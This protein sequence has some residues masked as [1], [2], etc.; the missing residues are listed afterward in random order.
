MRSFTS[1]SVLTRF[2]FCSLLLSSCLSSKKIDNFVAAQYNYQL[3]KIKNR[4]IPVLPTTSA[5]GTTISTTEPHT[6]VLPLV[7]YWVVDYRHTT[8][9]NS[10]IAVANFANAVN[11]TASRSLNQ[12]LNG[13]KLELTVE[14][15]PSTFAFVDKTHFIWL[16]IYVVHWD[17]IYIE[18]EA[19]DLIVSY[20]LL[21]NETVVKTGRI[22]VKNPEHNKGLRFFQSWKS[23][24]NEYIATYNSDIT[25]MAKQFVTSLS[26]EL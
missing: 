9:L 21:R 17:K 7:L 1:L 15:A 4:D 16:I 5:L 24:I 13:Q 2:L 20:K 6:K 25:V 3:P 23:A 22:A 8:N 26:D 19:K 10:Q 11:T 18:P 12:K 14:Q